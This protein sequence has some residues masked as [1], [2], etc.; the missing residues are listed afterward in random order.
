MSGMTTKDFGFVQQHSAW[1]YVRGYVD[2]WATTFN[3]IYYVHRYVDKNRS[4]A[5]D[6]F[7]VFDE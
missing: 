4:F 5:F 7:E 1:Q 3:M 2:Y 6:D